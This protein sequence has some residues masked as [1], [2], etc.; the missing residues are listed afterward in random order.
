MLDSMSQP[1]DPC[2]NVG[3]AKARDVVDMALP[4]DLVLRNPAAAVDSFQKLRSPQPAP[5]VE[6]HAT[7]ENIDLQ[8]C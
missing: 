6:L 3:G 5:Q 8:N 1:D 2:L 7:V 4:I